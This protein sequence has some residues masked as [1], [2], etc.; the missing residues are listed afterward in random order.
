MLTN[1]HGGFIERPGLKLKG[2]TTPV[3]I[4]APQAVAR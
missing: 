1:G 2:K 4:Y 3:Q